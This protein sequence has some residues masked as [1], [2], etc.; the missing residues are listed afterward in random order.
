MRELDAS[1]QQFGEFVL[2]AQLVNE[3]GAPYFVRWVGRFRDELEE[4]RLTECT[5]GDWVRLDLAYLAEHQTAAHPRVTSESVRDDLTH[6]ACGG[7]DAP[8]ILFRLAGPAQEFLISN[9]QFLIR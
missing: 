5:Y 2:R 3:N 4:L 1:L 9:S 8:R 6:L 7:N